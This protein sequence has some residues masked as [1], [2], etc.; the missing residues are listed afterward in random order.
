MPA[1]FAL[2]I[3]LLVAGCKKSDSGSAAGQ[4]CTP[5]VVSCNA[6]TTCDSITAVCTCPTGNKL[7]GGDCADIST[8]SYNCGGC[9]LA[10]P[11]GT[12]CV[13]GRCGTGC[14]TGA[15]D[16]NG[17]C[18]DPLTAAA[19]CGGCGK[20]CGDGQYCRFGNCVAEMCGWGDTW[21]PGS[22]CVNLPS[23]PNNCGACGA[24]CGPGLVCNRGVCANSCDA[25]LSNCN[26]ACVDLNHDPANCGQC[27]Q[28]CPQGQMCAS[29]DGVAKCRAYK[30]AA[31]S[32]CPCAACDTRVCCD[33]ASA[34]GVKTALCVESA[35]PLP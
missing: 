23:S 4:A 10:C 13:A 20:A 35:C 2:L 24:Q 14:A 16:C 33:V 34:T 8:D 22:D 11:G 5:N 28:L 32:S 29:Q 26:G 3:A 25:G 30:I 21:C 15:V 17:T 1:R 19:A 6:P 9:G 27:G 18:Y 12:T 7:C 31:C